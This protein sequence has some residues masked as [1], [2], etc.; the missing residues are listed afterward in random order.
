[1]A[2]RADSA[3]ATASRIVHAMQELF[4]ERPYP[5]IALSAIAER[6]EVTVQTVV[7]RFGSKEGVL[8]A[9]AEEARSRVVA[10]RAAAPAGNVPSAVRNLFDHYE[11]W[12]AVALRLVEQE[13]RVAEI[14]AIADEA[15]N[16][17]ARWVERVFEPELAAVGARARERRRAQLIAVT[18]VYVW[19]LLRRDMGLPR[20]AAE[21][22]VRDL[23]D[24][25]CARRGA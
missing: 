25:I 2:A 3:A 17:H 13:E 20:A 9:A 19:K 14:H 12:G 22:A 6:A 8:V 16:V 1:M 21:D 23:V 7:R 4:A 11:R 24:A 5:E 18:D 15:R 10:E